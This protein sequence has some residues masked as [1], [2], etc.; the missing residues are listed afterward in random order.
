MIISMRRKGTRY[1]LALVI[2]AALLSLLLGSCEKFFTTNLLSGLKRDPANLSP[3]QQVQYAQQALTSGDAAAMKSAFDALTSGG[4]SN[5]TT[6]QKVLAVQCANGAMD[7][8][9]QITTIAAEYDSDPNAANDLINQIAAGIDTTLVTSMKTIL[10]DLSSDPVNSPA[11]GIGASDYALAAISVG[12]LAVKTTT[13]DVTTVSS[14]NADVQLA[15]SYFGGAETVLSNG[16]ESTD[17][18][19]GVANLFSGV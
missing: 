13:G 6:E 9:S 5:M 3:E 19:T 12:L 10:N 16:G 1:R 11:A 8:Q 7:I 14:A 4:T 17:T 18:V 2:V 15:Q